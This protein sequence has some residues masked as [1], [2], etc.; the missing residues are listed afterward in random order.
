MPEIMTITSVGWGIAALAAWVAEGSNSSWWITP[1]PPAPP[2]WSNDETEHDCRWWTVADPCVERDTSYSAHRRVEPS[3]D[4]WSKARY[5]ALNNDTGCVLS[6]EVDAN[7][8]YGFFAYDSKIAD[9]RFYSNPELRVQSDTRVELQIYE[10]TH[11]LR[12]TTH[13]MYKSLQIEHLDTQSF[14]LLRVDAEGELAY[15]AQLLNLSTC[16]FAT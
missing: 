5:C 11:A 8:P 6:H 14:R 3:S 12:A 10:P 9:L 7:S 2:A 13:E 4:T 15:C 16:G 1:P